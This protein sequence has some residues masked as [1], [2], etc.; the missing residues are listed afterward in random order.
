MNRGYLNS[1]YF[2]LCIF[3]VLYARAARH[4]SNRA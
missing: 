2:F 4:D 3:L 1:L